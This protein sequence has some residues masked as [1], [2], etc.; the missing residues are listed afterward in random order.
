LSQKELWRVSE[1][2][3]MHHGKYGVWRSRRTA[4]CEGAPCQ[5]ARHD[6]SM[7]AK[8]LANPEER[9]VRRE[10]GY[11]EERFLRCVNQLLAGSEG[12]EE[13][14]AYFGMT[15][16]AVHGKLRGVTMRWRTRKNSL[17]D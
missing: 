3:R 12:E 9:S 16:L 17:G 8:I 7:K 2:R 11:I 6:K 15:V 14:S 1:L 13:A 5:V 4:R 10:G